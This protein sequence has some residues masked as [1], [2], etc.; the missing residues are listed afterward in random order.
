MTGTR[1]S[2]PII[3]YHTAQYA[4]YAYC[5]FAFLSLAISVCGELGMPISMGH[6]V[7]TVEHLLLQLTPIVLWA[8]FSLA[9]PADTRLLRYC[10]KV[11]TICYMLTFILGL[12]FRSNL[13][14][15]TEDGQTPQ[16]VTVL[17][18]IQGTIGLLSV[19]ASLMA[20]CHLYSKYKGNM[21]KLGIALVM[22]FLVWLAGSNIIPSA[23]FYLAGNTQQTAI[24]C[25]NIIIEVSST[26]VY[27]YAYYM[28]CRAIN[29]GVQD[30]PRD[31]T[32]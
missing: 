15:M 5:I 28:M 10:S 6:M 9:L 23:V 25:V 30:T 8:M 7:L 22:V 19:I 12:C 26:S 21:H 24:T 17:T 29:D 13:V 18:W 16:M 31:K 11:V 32:M 20:G 27:I 2:I 1:K 14:T 4:M 3:I